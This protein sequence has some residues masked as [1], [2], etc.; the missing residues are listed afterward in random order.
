MCWSSTTPRHGKDLDLI[1]RELG[2]LGARKVRTCVF[3]DQTLATARRDRARPA[4]IPRR[5]PVRGRLRPRL[6]GSVP[7]L[8]YVGALRAEILGG[9]R[10]AARQAPERRDPNLAP[11]VVARI[12][13]DSPE[14]A[15]GVASPRGWTEAL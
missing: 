11:V 1:R 15:V 10:P 6:R 13:T 12:R 8:P 4:R 9:V 2:R 7:E 14:T 5:R 3:L